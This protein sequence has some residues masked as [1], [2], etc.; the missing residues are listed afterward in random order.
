MP[1]VKRTRLFVGFQNNTNETTA[2]QNV[3]ETIPFPSTGMITFRNEGE[4]IVVD[5][6]DVKFTW[7]GSPKWFKIDNLGNIFKGSGTAVDR[8][9]EVVWFKNGIQEGIVRQTHMN[10]RNSEIISGSG[11]LYLDTGDVLEPKIRNIDND[12]KILVTNFT[13]CFWEDTGY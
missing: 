12:D 10:S 11:W 5:P 4:P 9:V 8:K 6:T 13:A 7:N 1:L 2:L 3:W